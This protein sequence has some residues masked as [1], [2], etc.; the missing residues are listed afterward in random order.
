MHLTYNAVDTGGRASN[1]SIEAGSIRD[2]VEQL[3]RRGLF[4]TNIAESTHRKKAKETAAQNAAGEGSARL[5]LKKLSHMTRQIAMLLRSGSGI[6][7]AFMAIQRQTARPSHNALLGQIITDLEDG[8]PLTDALRKHPQTFDAVYCAIV[9][10]GE[11]SGTL[12]EMFDRLS[13]IVGKSRAM[14]K[15]ILG[16][17]AY[18]CLLTIMCTKIFF[19]LLLFVIPRFA[20]M[21]TQLGVKPPATT[22]MLLDAGVVVRSY[23]PFLLLGLAALVGGV[24]WLCTNQRGKDWISNIQL[25]IPLVGRLRS[26]LIQGQIFRTL[27]TLLES[28]VNIMEALDLVRHSTRNQKFQGL[29][30][31]LTGAL[32]SGGRLSTTFE[33]SGLVEAYLCQAIHTGEDTG[34]LGGAMSFAADMLDETNEELINMVMKL[35]EPVILIGMGFVV[36]GIAISLFMPLFDLTS[37]IK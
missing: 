17:F 31:D 19:V 1:D 22:V 5:P 27:G 37:G 2:A 29:F 7:P 36:G 33:S 34:N 14:R 10:A 16:A 12:T 8:V 35:M 11:A 4:V 32:E 25:Y 18:P 24:Y 28:R 23:W 20:D 6:V 21:F 26:R 30:H 9:A 3:R 15:K 13:V